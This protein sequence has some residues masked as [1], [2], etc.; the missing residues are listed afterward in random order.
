[1]PF[2]V[3]PLSRLLV[4]VTLAL[5][6]VCAQRSAGQDGK[7]VGKEVVYKTVVG[8]PLHLYL[9]SPPESMQGPHAAIVFFHGGGG[10]A[11][12]PAQFNSQATRLAAL[13]MVAIEVEYRL[14]AP[15]PSMEPPRVCVEDAKS[16]MRW[17]RSHAAELNVDPYKD[18][19][20]R[21][22]RRRISGS[23]SGLGSRMGWSR[24]RP[25]R[26]AKTGSARALLSRAGYQSGAG[27]RRQPLRS[28]LG[29]VRARN[30]SE[31]EG[32]S[33]DYLCWTRGQDGDAQGA[34]SLQRTRRSS[35]KSL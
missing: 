33:H 2:H 18:R 25:E 24:R 15:P 22:F 8:R 32:A 5:A 23:R 10:T 13:G 9:S 20:R 27:L 30:V 34:A 26:L 29:K 6:F 19:S 14:L 35:R 31:C 16:A 3:P 4:L 21:W 28:G 7:P 1:M 11:G 12:A 17:V